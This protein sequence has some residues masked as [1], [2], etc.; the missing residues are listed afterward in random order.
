MNATQGDLLNYHLLVNTPQGSSSAAYPTTGNLRWRGPYVNCNTPVDPW[1]RP[2]VI[3]VIAG[4][5]SNATNYKRLW[6]VSAGANGV[7]D[8]NANAT[9]TTELGG[10]DIGMMLSQ[11]Q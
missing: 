3:N 1:G 7:F 5:S 4:Y 2:Y 10:D 8:T 9:A 6:V 11:R